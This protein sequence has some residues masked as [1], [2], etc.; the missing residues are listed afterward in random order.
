MKKITTNIL[1]LILFFVTVFTNAQVGFN[2]S[3]PNAQLEIKSSNQPTPVNTDG[4]LI[5]K[6]DVFPAINPTSAQQGML[7]YLTTINGTNLPGFYYWDNISLSWIMLVK[8]NPNLFTHYIGEL[9]GGGIIVSVWKVAGVEHG[10]IASLV[11]MQK[12]A[13]PTYNIPWTTAAKTTSLANAKSMFDGLANTTAILTQNGDAPNTAA[14]VCRHYSGGGFNDWY[15]PANQELESCYNAAV[16]VNSIIGSVNGFRFSNGLPN[17]YWSSTEN[18]A[19]QAFYKAFN[20]NST[21]IIGKKDAINIPNGCY[22]RA[23]RRF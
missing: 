2:T 23:V 8:S 1:F 9:Y 21:D 4:I 13:A 10:L 14:Y 22:V 15:L 16:I 20:I 19:T 7:V 12:T 17:A 5:P 3:I 18:S 11:D 6:I